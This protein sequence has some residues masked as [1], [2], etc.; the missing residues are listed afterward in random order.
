MK[1]VYNSGQS[2]V[3]LWIGKNSTAVEK[4]EATFWAVSYINDKG[5]PK[6]TPVVRISEGNG[7]EP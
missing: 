5:L 2:T 1:I 7:V 3:F 4:K 6:S